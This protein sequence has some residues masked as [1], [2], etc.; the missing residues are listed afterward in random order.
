[1]YPE[2]SHRKSCNLSGWVSIPSIK[3][4]RRI[5]KSLSIIIQSNGIDRSP[6]IVSI[7]CSLWR[8]NIKILSELSCCTTYFYG[9]SWYSHIR[10]KL[11]QLIKIQF[12]SQCWSI[13]I[14]VYLCWIPV[15][16]KLLQVVTHISGDKII[17]FIIYAH[18]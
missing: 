7:L 15:V 11:S 9:D 18:W 4:Q 8:S 2:S 16:L 14:P 17:D 3:S 6:I 1:M 10:K 5:L 13:N 12:I